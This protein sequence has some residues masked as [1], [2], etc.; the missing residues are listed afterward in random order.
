MGVCFRLVLPHF[1]DHLVKKATFKCLKD[2]LVIY[3]TCQGV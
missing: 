1:N 3:E 2:D